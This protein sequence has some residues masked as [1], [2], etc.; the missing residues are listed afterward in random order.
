M[1]RCFHD[2]KDDLMHKMNACRKSTTSKASR[3]HREAAITSLSYDLLAVK[4]FIFDVVRV[5]VG[6]IVSRTFKMIL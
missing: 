4:S 2:I 3:I 1:I 6:R 5:V